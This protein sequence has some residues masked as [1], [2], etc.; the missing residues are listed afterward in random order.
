M[1]IIAGKYKGRKLESPIGND[2]RPTSDKVR[3]AVFSS[4]A[5]DVP[6]A[7]CV[8]L[9]A[10]SGAIGIEALSRGA[11]RV[12]FGDVSRDSMELTKRNC[13]TVGCSNDA[14]FFLGEWRRVLSRVAEEAKG[15]V[16]IVF[17]DPPYKAGIYE[18][19]LAEIARLELLEEDGVLM[20]EHDRRDVLPGEIAGLRL[21]RERGYG[22]TTVS[23]YG[24]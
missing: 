15:R 9:F 3:E 12:Y 22:K 20:L 8:D 23:Y 4:L 7:V 6:D 16:G 13:R 17:I 5:A 10:G 11:K 21:L 18:D 2:V 24:F 19:V 14:S 1:R